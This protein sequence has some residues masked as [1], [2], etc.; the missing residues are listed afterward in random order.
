MGYHNRVYVSPTASFFVKN[1]SYL[2][3]ILR[4]IPSIYRQT[5][6]SSNYKY[7]NFMEIKIELNWWFVI[8]T[9]YTL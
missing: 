2:I 8:L 4:P 9:Y 3:L 5:F 7:C 1:E 6:S